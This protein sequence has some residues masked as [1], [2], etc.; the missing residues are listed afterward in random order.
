[1][2]CI[3]SNF[4]EK[5]STDRNISDVMIFNGVTAS[6]DRNVRH[7]FINI[8]DIAVKRVK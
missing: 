3:V 6:G 1:M 8:V 7:V 5:E 4:K 2:V